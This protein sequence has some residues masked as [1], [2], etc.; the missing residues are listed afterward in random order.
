MATGT[1]L[2]NSPPEV[3]KGPPKKHNIYRRQKLQNKEQ[4]IA[5]AINID[6]MDVIS[7]HKMDSNYSLE[8]FLENTLAIVNNHMPLKKMS[9][10]DFKL[11]AKPWI[12]PGMIT[13]IKRRDSLLREYIKCPEGDRKNDLHIQY[14]VLRNKIVA[15]MRLSKNNHLRN[16]FSN[17]SDKSKVKS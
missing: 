16:Y 17:N 13:S 1:G 6:W 14:K 2:C 3:L 15:L 9:K 4:L 7:P 11:E 12:T 10:K 8:K 5:D